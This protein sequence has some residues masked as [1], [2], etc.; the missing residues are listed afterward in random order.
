[1]VFADTL[2]VPEWYGGFTIMKSA[3]IEVR[4]S[5]HPVIIAGLMDSVKYLVNCTEFLRKGEYQN[6]ISELN[7]NEKR[8]SI[9]ASAILGREL[10]EAEKPYFY[11]LCSHH[12]E[13]LEIRMVASTC[14]TY[15]DTHQ[16]LRS[17]MRELSVSGTIPAYE[18]RYMVGMIELLTEIVTETIK[19]LS[20]Q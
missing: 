6:A 12:A 13:T 3:R 1:M 15:R 17:K 14:K 11:N 18:V 19:E 8:P 20:K 2:S 5:D 4:K 16:L 7:S 9:L 10:T